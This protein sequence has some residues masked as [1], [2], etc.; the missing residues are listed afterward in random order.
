[1]KL[2]FEQISPGFI[3][4]S[5]EL[6]RFLGWLTEQEDGS[7]NF[8]KSDRQAIKFLPSTPRTIRTTVD[9][10]EQDIERIVI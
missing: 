8:T 4:V 10:C 1:M 5:D 3:R 7:L 2:T 6:E 9:T